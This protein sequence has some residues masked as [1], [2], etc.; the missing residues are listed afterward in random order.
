LY[1]HAI[2][3]TH[4]KFISAINEIGEDQVFRAKAIAILLQEQTQLNTAEF[5]F[6]RILT[7]EEK[8][9]GPDHTTT[10]GILNNLGILYSDQGKLDEAEQMYLRASTG[11]ERQLGQD[12]PRTRTIV[13]NLAKLRRQQGNVNID[14]P[15]L[16]TD[17][18]RR[19]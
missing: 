6:Y 9:L 1:P 4:S 2:R 16:T 15:S 5:I 13:G 18:K 8:A 11:Y 3:L 14:S 17:K 7:Y 10:L 12:H 19:R